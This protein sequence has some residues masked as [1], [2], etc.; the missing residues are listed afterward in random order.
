MRTVEN[1][2]GRVP[3][4]RKATNTKYVRIDKTSILFRYLQVILTEEEDPVYITFDN[5]FNILCII[6]VDGLG[7]SSLQDH[8]KISSSA[9]LEIHCKHLLRLQLM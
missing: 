1:H 9:I 3:D 4:M 7:Q 5:D 8:V 6:Y 2:P